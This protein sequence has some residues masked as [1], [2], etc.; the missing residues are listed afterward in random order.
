[1]SIII[2][3]KIKEDILNSVKIITIN[4]LIN[5]FN[6]KRITATNYLSRLEKDGLITRIGRGIYLPLQKSKLKPEIDPKIEEINNIIKENSPY[7]EFI[8]WSIFN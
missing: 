1:M 5:K 3:E 4:N 8:I 6:I 2:P 7:L